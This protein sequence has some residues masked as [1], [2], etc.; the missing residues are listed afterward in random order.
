MRINRLYIDGFRHFADRAVESLDSPV[1]VF[2]G[3]NEAGKSTL[4]AFIRAILYGFPTYRGAQHYPP[5]AGGRHGGRITL[6]DGDSGHRYV[7]TRRQGTRGG[8]VSVATES[9]Q[10]QDAGMLAQLLGH[11]PSNVFTNIFT[12]TLDELHSDDMLT[13][14]NLNG[15]IYAAGMGA[16][17]LP[18]ALNS[19]EDERSK[20]FVV[21][22]R[23]G[24]GPSSQ[25]IYHAARDLRDID[26]RLR[27]VEGNAARYGSLTTQIQQIEADLVSAQ[28]RQRLIRSKL[29]HQNNLKNSW[30][31]WNSLV[32]AEQQ[33]AGMPV[34]ERFPADGVSRLD[35]LQAGV[36]TARRERDDVAENV[37]RIRAKLDIPVQGRD[38]LENP[39]DIRT[40]QT[41]SGALRQSIHDLPEREAEL[42]EHCK[43]LAATLADL[44]PDWDENRLESFD[45]SI[46]VRE[47]IRGFQN[48][49][50]GVTDQVERSKTDLRQDTAALEDSQAALVRAEQHAADAERPTLDATRVDERRTLVRAA[51]AKLADIDR[52]EQRAAD[53]QIQLDGL[54]VPAA[55]SAGRSGRAT[56]IAAAASIALG[57]ALLIG[58]AVL[59]DAGLVIGIVA[60]VALLA[61]GAYLYVTRPQAAGQ[62][63]ESPLAPGLRESLRRA[64][65]NAGELHTALLKET[66]LLEL[67]TVDESQLIAAESSLDQ[68]STRLS[69]RDRLSRML[70]DAGRHVEERAARAEQSACAATSAEQE[71]EDVNSAWRE[72][73]RKRSLRDSVTPE[74]VGEIRA[75]VVSGLDRLANVREWQNRVAAIETDIRQYIEIAAPLASEF[76]IPLDHDDHAAVVAAADRLIELY[77]EVQQAVRQREAAS[78]EYEEASGHL[79]TREKHLDA[80]NAEVADLLDAGDAADAEDFRVR[81]GLHQKRADL[82]ET[83]RAARDRLQRMSGPGDAL[84]S[85]MA[86]LGAANA[87]SIEDEIRR[88]EDQQVD[89]DSEVEELSTARGSILMELQGLAGEEKSSALRARRWVLLEQI[90]DHAREWTKLTIARNLLIEARGKFERE[91]QPGVIRHAAAFFSEI[92]GGRYGQ[93]YAPLGE[94]TITVTDA[95]GATKTPAELSRGTREQLFLSLRFGLIRD[96]GERTEPLPVVVDEALVNFDTERALRAAHMFVEVAQ[97]NQVLVFTCQPSMIDLFQ[98][99]ARESGTQQPTVIGL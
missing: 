14:P 17:M 48:K 10:P 36:A 85:F 90:R 11:H 12:F 73:L 82:N 98:N 63:T 99:A 15:Q 95:N 6:S 76:D 71:L 25:K 74:T 66:T 97:T 37:E 30:D 46:A 65:Q 52:V 3:E 13:N 44:G 68:E 41:E 20:L 84:A 83:A 70:A 43:N 49:I 81:A 78:S 22:G 92:T 18:S 51:R 33:M 9:G 2:Y 16:A 91:R 38:I 23:G 26:S 58:G 27:E 47:E 86:D 60:G 7:I 21:G 89:L 80:A 75:E 93:V 19:I 62:P 31:D 56:T 64:R 88:L 55:S 29:A 96:M 57:I 1:T 79:G 24:G 35:T 72:W 40:L 53:L 94:Q 45:I 28:N 5:L 8:P 77:A 34:I 54:A 59:G 69:E 50:R 32:S 42:A 61:I 4:M 67:E 87:Q 39:D